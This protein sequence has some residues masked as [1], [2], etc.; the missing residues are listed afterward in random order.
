MLF[1]VE[2]VKGT[3]KV[4][5]PFSYDGVEYDDCESGVGGYWCLTEG[6]TGSGRDYSKCGECVEPTT[7]KYY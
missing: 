4:C 5:T 2:C 3:N 6:Q 7:G 1:Y